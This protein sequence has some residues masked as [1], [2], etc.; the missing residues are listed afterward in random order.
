MTNESVF[1][2]GP[3]EDGDIVVM[4]ERYTWT[5]D[6]NPFCFGFTLQNVVSIG[7]EVQVEVR[8]TKL[9]R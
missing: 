1:T 5:V 9:S 3:D 4:R 7:D 6:E 2:L 8:V